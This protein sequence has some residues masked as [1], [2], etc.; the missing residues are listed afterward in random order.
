[1]AEIGLINTNEHSTVRQAFEGLLIPYPLADLGSGEFD[2]LIYTQQG[3]S[4]W[5]RKVIPGDFISS[6]ADGRLNR[7]LAAIREI[8]KFPKLILEGRL[9]FN[10][11]GNL[12]L[13]RRTSRWTRKGLRNLLRS[14]RYIEGVDVEWSDSLEETV[15]IVKEWWEY[16][17]KGQHL[18]LKVR[19]GLSSNW[20]YTVREER[21]IYFYEGIPGISAVRARALSE[22]FPNPIDLV[23]AEPETIKE[24]SGFGNKLSLR[25][26]N[27]LR[28]NLE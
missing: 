25:V 5:E 17:D 26:F 11:D 16:L 20:P 28:G 6:I 22:I 15:Q 23:A 21:I 3:E 8:S 24:I 19:P 9:T 12:L 1:M 10:R 13:N 14:I 2:M 27:F 18:S 4:A 7:E